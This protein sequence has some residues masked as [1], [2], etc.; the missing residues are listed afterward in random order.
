MK[1]Q[2]NDYSRGCHT[3]ALWT[4]NV[5]F[6]ANVVFLIEDVAQESE[7]YIL[8]HQILWFN[9]NVDSLCKSIDLKKKNLL[10]G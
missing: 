2:C 10:V 4:F 5:A 9:V 1:K 6:L 8:Q 7:T 3:M